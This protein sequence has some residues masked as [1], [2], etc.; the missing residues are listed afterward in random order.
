MFDCPHCGKQHEKINHFCPITGMPIP[1]GERMLGQTLLGKY[2]IVE[3][4]GE[5]FAGGT[6]KV[7]E[8]SGGEKLFISKVVHPQYLKN[9]SVL[10]EY[11]ESLKKWMNIEHENVAKVFEIGKDASGAP[12]LIREHIPGISLEKF[13]SALNQNEVKLALPESAWILKGILQALSAI[14]ETGIKSGRLTPSDI[15]LIE[16][17]GGNLEIKA[18]DFG[19]YILENAVPEA[20][21]NKSNI[22]LY[23][24]P[25]QVREGITEDAS[26][27]FSAGV[28]LYRL[29]TGRFPYPDG[30]PPKPDK[31]PGF[32]GATEIVPELPSVIDYNLRRAMAI[33]PKDRFKNAS[34]FA[35]T[36]QGFLAEE[37]VKLNKLL[38]IAS[39][40]TSHIA[41][42]PELKTRKE[43]ESA[44]PQRS[45]MGTIRMEYPISIPPPEIATGATQ[46][47]DSSTP[48]QIKEAIQRHSSPPEAPP[49]APVLPYDDRTDAWK[50]ER[51]LVPRTSR[52]PT[53]PPLPPST[54]ESQSKPLAPPPPSAVNVKEIETQSKDRI[55]ETT[56]PKT[57]TSVKRIEIQEESLA[58]IMPTRHLKWFILG[59]IALVI[60][61]LIWG[62][63]TYFVGGKPSKNIIAQQK[64]KTG[65]TI[66][67]ENSYN[68]EE[69]NEKQA[70]NNITPITNEEKK[71]EGEQQKETPEEKEGAGSLLE[72]LNPVKDASNEE[73]VETTPTPTQFIVLTLKVKPQEAEV[74]LDG[75]KAAKPFKFK[76]E[77]SQNIHNIKVMRDG[78]E[79][80]EINIPATQD[81]IIEVNLQKIQSQT[82]ESQEKQV[83]EEKEIQAQKTTK[84]KTKPRQPINRKKGK[85]KSTFTEEVPF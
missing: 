68:K 52:P 64:P 18:T 54:T 58:P 84:E 25:E 23:R 3:F 69:Q 4:L 11:L 37:P 40:A 39:F 78:F 35:Q 79:P 21:K 8:T 17:D 15:F 83:V 67:P 61:V 32:I 53:K 56:V 71:I 45:K 81:K 38:Q 20:S 77:K 66:A 60:L 14:H 72:G 1:F 59:G 63:K 50:E 6:F 31:V 80:F 2:Q 36:L 74:F 27:I 46:K 41:E 85:G 57:A 28:I 73:V 12:I 75:Q 42:A 33:F 48:S 76:L 70:D 43:E 29:L 16:G 26:D 44:K 22:I 19:E 7:K 5:W 55:P 13:I 65:Q 9:Q 10:T 24:A 82:V 30:I 62:M 34:Q 51:K 47:F 49:S